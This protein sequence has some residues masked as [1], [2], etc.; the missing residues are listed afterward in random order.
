VRRL[1]RRTRPDGRGGTSG[2]SP[3]GLPHCIAG[4]RARRPTCGFRR[5]GCPGRPRGQTAPG[6]PDA[7]RAPACK[8]TDGASPRR[9]AHRDRGNAGPRQRNDEG[10][11]RPVLRRELTTAVTTT[12][13]TTGHQQRTAK[14]GRGADRG[15]EATD[16]VLPESRGGS[17]HR[18]RVVS[19]SDVTSPHGRTRTGA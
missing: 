13:L 15:P 8:I 17:D 1:E 18:Q 19:G 12:Q 5:G 2:R 9:G 16:C 10:C 7:T 3:R 14:P 11:Q 4:A 6:R